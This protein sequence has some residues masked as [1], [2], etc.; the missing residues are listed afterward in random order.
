MAEKLQ[1]KYGV[2]ICSSI[3][4]HFDSALDVDL[5]ALEKLI[6]ITASHMGYAG[7]LAADGERAEP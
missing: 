3:D 7:Q 1:L 5:L 4:G 6:S 2:L